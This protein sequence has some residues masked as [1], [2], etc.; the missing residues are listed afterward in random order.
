MNGR[1][2]N[3]AQRRY[4]GRLIPP[5]RLVT[6]ETTMSPTSPPDCHVAR[7]IDTAISPASFDNAVSLDPH[8]FPHDGSQTKSEIGTT[9]R[10]RSEVVRRSF[11][12]P[13]PDDGDPDRPSEQRTVVYRRQGDWD[14]AGLRAKRTTRW[15]KS[16][17]SVGRRT[18]ASL[19]S[20]S[21][22]RIT[23]RI[24]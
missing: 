8:P 24:L 20:R 13:W 21:G 11:K 2:G 22:S 23:W 10:N 5:C 16:I 1:M 12:Q 9:R 19:P 7:A 6:R 4:S 18:S 17:P 15:V 14:E 3:N